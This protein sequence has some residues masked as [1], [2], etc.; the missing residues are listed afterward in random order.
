M[1]TTVPKGLPQ[2]DSQRARKFAAL[3]PLALVLICVLIEVV[4]QMGDLGVFGPPRLRQWAYEQGGFWPGLLQDWTPNYA[5][6]PV[7]MFV[8]YGFLHGGLL[9]LLINMITLHSLGQGVVE[10]VG[11]VQFLLLYFATMIGGAAGFGLI[12]DT[13]YPMVGASGALFG[14]AGALMAW[15]YVDRYTYRLDLWPI[16]RVAGLLIVI[17][18]V[19]WWALDGQLAW[20]THLGGFVTGWI[21]ALLLDPRGRI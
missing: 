9:H 7:L 21:M 1:R 18:A 3:V 4:L 10:R 14:L 15:N 2:D 5:L 11:P 16:A 13:V 17:N 8:T 12:A 6:Q 19:M 20:E